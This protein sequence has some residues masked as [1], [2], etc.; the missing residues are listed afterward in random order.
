MRVLAGRGMSLSQAFLS[1][2]LAAVMVITRMGLVGVSTF[3]IVNCFD[4]NN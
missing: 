2:I 4:L 3:H 1:I